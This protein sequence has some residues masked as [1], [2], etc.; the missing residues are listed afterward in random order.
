MLTE[1]PSDMNR[2]S[3]VPAAGHNI[4]PEVTKLL[5]DNAQLFH[6]LL[7][8]LLYL[9]RRTR[10]YIQTAVAFLCTRVKELDKDDYN[11]LTKAK[12]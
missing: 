1:L 8:K 7:A 9:C 4:N 3:K 12:I 5:E 11:K 2:V 10:Q 6:P